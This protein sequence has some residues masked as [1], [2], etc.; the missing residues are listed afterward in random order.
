MSLGAGWLVAGWRGER[1]GCKEAC[2]ECMIAMY[3][4]ASLFI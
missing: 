3:E 1:V 2:N 4:Y